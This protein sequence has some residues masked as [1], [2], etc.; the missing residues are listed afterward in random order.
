MTTAA[1]TR[2]RP[3]QG[4]LLLLPALLL[5][6]MGLLGMHVLGLHGTP[7]AQ[8]GAVPAVVDVIAHDATSSVADAVVGHSHDDH[9]HDQDGA[10]EHLHAAVACVFLLFLAMVGILPPRLLR[11]WAPGLVRERATRLRPVAVTPRPP[12][13]H[14]LCI[15]RT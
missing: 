3:G 6:I 12:S 14:A 1:Y 9:R 7:A 4:A 5:L 15:S 2:S 13:L 10:A 11:L 8:A